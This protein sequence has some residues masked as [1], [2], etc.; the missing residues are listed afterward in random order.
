MC[1]YM[2]VIEGNDPSFE[3]YETPAYPSM[4]YH[5]I[6]SPSWIRTTLHGL[7]VR[8]LHLV[9]LRGIKMV[10]VVGFE[11]TTPWSQTRCATQTVPHS[12]KWSS[13]YDSHVNVRWTPTRLLSDCKKMVPHERI[14]LPYPD[15]KTGVIPLY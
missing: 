13:H 9:C 15:Y 14:E 3:A 2:V 11:P 7:T 4:L 5:R 6:G 10:G 1:F 12:E 8:R